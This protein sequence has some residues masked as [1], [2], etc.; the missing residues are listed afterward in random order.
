MFSQCYR[1]IATYDFYLR[2]LDEDSEI[3]VYDKELVSVCK[4]MQE[5]FLYLLKY[6]VLCFPGL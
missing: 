6:I 3:E 2:M 4:S 5:G 1:Y